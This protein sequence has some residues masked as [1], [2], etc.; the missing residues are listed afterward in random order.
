MHLCV[1]YVIYLC[2][3]EYFASRTS[4][5]NACSWTTQVP[6]WSSANSY[7]GQFSMWVSFQLANQDDEGTYGD[8]R[9][10]NHRRYCK[11][12]VYTR[13][14]FVVRQH[15]DSLFPQL[16]PLCNSTTKQGGRRARN[17]LLF[18]NLNGLRVRVNQ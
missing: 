4:N 8:G 7:H 6:L 10:D 2:Q 17:C 11:E 1:P 5:Q 14:I 3:V 18:M 15:I 9:D 12:Q 16:W 13:K